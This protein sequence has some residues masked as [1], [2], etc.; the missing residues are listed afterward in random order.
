MVSGLFADSREFSSGMVDIHS[1]FC[2]KF[3]KG[4]TEWFSLKSGNLDYF[5][6]W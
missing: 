3:L 4:Y 5:K 2:H 6:I 1:R